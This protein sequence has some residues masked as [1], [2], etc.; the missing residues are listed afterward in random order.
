MSRTDAVE[1]WERDRLVRFQSASRR[2]APRRQTNHFSAN[3]PHTPNAFGGTP[4]AAGEDAR[5]PKSYCIVTA[6]FSISLSEW[7]F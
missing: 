4:K 2:L 7:I 3:L 1:K 6:K 5:A